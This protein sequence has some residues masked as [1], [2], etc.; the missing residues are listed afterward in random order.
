MV[1]EKAVQ[2]V[3]QKLKDSERE[4]LDMLIEGHTYREITARTGVSIGKISR[5]CNRDLRELFIEEGLNEQ[6]LFEFGIY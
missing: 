2:N 1:K 6:D 5:F 3:R 4:I